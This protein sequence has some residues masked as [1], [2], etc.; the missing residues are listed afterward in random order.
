MAEAEYFA[1]I[2]PDDPERMTYWRRGPRGLKPW[3]QKATYGPVLRKSDVP[4]VLRGEARREWV[5]QWFGE[6]RPWSEAVHE[7]IDADPDGCRARFAAFT[8]RCCCCGRALTDPASKTYGI[9]PECRDGVSADVLARMVEQI[10]R[11]HAAEVS[12]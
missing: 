5:R 6:R 7:A 11:L 4:A 2:D 8:S 10:G 9:G 1:V 3:P 12:R